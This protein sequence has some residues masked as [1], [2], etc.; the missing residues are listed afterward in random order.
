MDGLS[1][2]QGELDIPLHVGRGEIAGV[3]TLVKLLHFTV[4]L[5]KAPVEALEMDPEHG[6]LVVQ[7]PEAVAQVEADAP[8]A[9]VVLL[10]VAGGGGLGLPEELAVPLP[11]GGEDAG[12]GAA[13]PLAP[14]DAQ[15]LQ[16]GPLPALGHPEQGIAHGLPVLYR[17][18]GVV[19]PLVHQP[20][21]GPQ[22]LALIRGEI[23]HHLPLIEVGQLVPVHSFQF[24]RSNS[25]FCFKFLPSRGAPVPPGVVGA[26]YQI[27][28]G[29][30]IEIR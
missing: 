28:Q 14:Q 24:H 15:V 3:D 11:Q 23:V 26:A 1:G 30:I 20:E 25:T 27:I 18:Q 21:H 9:Q 4:I 29:D 5:L 22:W 12:P 10:R 19:L 17:Q 13:V 6:A 8:P 16:E 7:D 2:C